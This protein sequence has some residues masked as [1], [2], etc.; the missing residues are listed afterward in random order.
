M[1]LTLKADKR[2]RVKWYVVA[3][4]M[5]HSDFKSHTASILKMVKR[6]IVSVPQ[7]QKTEHEKQHEMKLV[8]AHEA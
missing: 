2:S 3:P 1:W 7:K 4:L 8:D 6:E 5:V